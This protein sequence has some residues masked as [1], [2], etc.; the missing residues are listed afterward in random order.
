MG[1]LSGDAVPFDSSQILNRVKTELRISND[2][3][4]ARLLLLIDEGAYELGRFKAV[5]VTNENLSPLDLRFIVIYV[6]IAYDGPD[7]ALDRALSN[8]TEKVRDDQ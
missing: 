7:D 2:A 8:V 5:A 1:A 3:D 4:D 6:A